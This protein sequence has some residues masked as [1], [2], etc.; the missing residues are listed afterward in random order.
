M[1]RSKDGNATFRAKTLSPSLSVSLWL[2]IWLWPH[3]TSKHTRAQTR[4]GLISTPGK[5]SVGRCKC[6]VCV[7][8]CAI[9]VFACG[10]NETAG[11]DEWTK[12]GLH[13]TLPPP[14]PPTP[15]PHVACDQ[16]SATR[17]RRRKRVLRCAAR[18]TSDEFGVRCTH[19]YRRQL[20]GAQGASS[21]QPPSRYISPSVCALNNLRVMFVTLID[22]RASTAALV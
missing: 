8:L 21:R 12:I 6:A 15:L 4:G 14:P 3:V 1:R 10:L 11:W 16:A 17:V 19:F 20:T 13:Y 7:C 2:R 22:Y 18:R 5:C 9:R